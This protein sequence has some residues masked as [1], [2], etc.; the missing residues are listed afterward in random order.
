MILDY[1]AIV[2]RRCSPSV[3]GVDTPYTS[4]LFPLFDNHTSV[5]YAYLNATQQGS[6]LT[7]SI[8][9][10]GKVEMKEFGD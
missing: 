3:S 5:F 2:S 9:C 8:S 1:V 6:I 4:D 7:L 10:V